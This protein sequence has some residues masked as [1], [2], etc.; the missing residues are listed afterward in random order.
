MKKNPI[1]NDSHRQSISVIFRSFYFCTWYTPSVRQ[2]DTDNYQLGQQIICH[3]KCQLLVI[4]GYQLKCVYI[5]LA[6]L[7]QG[8]IHTPVETTNRISIK[9]GRYKRTKEH[10]EAKP[11]QTMRKKQRMMKT[12]PGGIQ[13]TNLATKS[14]FG[15]S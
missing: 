13:L 12:I 8:Y 9:T 3:D 5:A 2:F 11:P 4:R 6:F 7:S 1:A 10:T 14:S 15:I